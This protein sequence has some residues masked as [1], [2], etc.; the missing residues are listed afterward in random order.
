MFHVVEGK[1]QIVVIPQSR[2]LSNNDELFEDSHSK[3]TKIDFS[4]LE[5]LNPNGYM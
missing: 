3:G 5:P 2:S 1:H 4:K